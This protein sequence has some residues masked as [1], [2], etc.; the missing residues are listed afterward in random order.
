MKN[1]VN[2]PIAWEIPSRQKSRI[3][4]SEMIWNASIAWLAGFFLMANVAIAGVGCTGNVTRLPYPDEAGPPSPI[5]LGSAPTESREEPPLCSKT[6]KVIWKYDGGSVEFETPLP[7][8][9]RY[10]SS[11]DWGDPQ[12]FRGSK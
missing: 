3:Q 8:D 1:D 11:R 5:Q 2:V 7:C 12:P 9:P 6:E 4:Y 10:D